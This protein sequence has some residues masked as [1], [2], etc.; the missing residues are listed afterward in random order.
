MAYAHTEP[1]MSPAS[2]VMVIMVPGQAGEEK[3]DREK[4]LKT[5]A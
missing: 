5:S 4:E 1:A 3:E 2:R